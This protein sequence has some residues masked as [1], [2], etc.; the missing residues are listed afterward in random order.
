MHQLTYPNTKEREKL[1]EIK[2]NYNNNLLVLDQMGLFSSPE[3]WT[4]D[5]FDT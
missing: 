3:L 1:P 2:I 4:T 5:N